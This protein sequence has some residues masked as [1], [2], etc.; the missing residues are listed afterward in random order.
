MKIVGECKTDTYS[1][2]I[3]NQIAS[4]IDEYYGKKADIS[5]DN[6]KIQELSE[7]KGFRYKSIYGIDYN[8]DKI[9][10]KY[11]TI[12]CFE[13]L[14][15]LQN[16][17]MLMKNIVDSLNPNGIVYV[18]LPSRPKML[19]PD[20]HYNEIPRDRL[21]KWIFQ[22]LGLRIEKEKFIK[23]RPKLRVKLFIGFRPIIRLF[24]WNKY[25]HYIYKL[26]CSNIV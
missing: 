11:D 22:P 26:K 4:F 14:E 6:Q 5:P 24:L 25:G 2:K 21:N 8:F 16:P 13:V 15:H 3:I 9:K 18:S 7:I 17:L 12:F 19:W 23:V 1:D 20:F 10:G